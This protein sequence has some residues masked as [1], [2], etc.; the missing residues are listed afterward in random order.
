MFDVGKER[1]LWFDLLLTDDRPKKCDN[2]VFDCLAVVVSVVM[3]EGRSDNESIH[4]GISLMF[5]EQ[6]KK[7]NI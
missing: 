6:K 1:S 5:I 7:K 2:F 3:E 4:D